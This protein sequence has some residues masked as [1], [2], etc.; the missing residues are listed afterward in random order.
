ML[1]TL[2]SFQT[3]SGGWSKHVD[4]RGP[5]RMPGESFYSEDDRW[6]YIATIDNDATT[7]HLRFL[8]A[9]F[10]AT[11]DTRARDGFTRGIAYLLQAQF[12]NGG[13]P[14]VYPLQGGYHDAITFNDNAMINVLRLLSDVVIGRFPFVSTALRQRA[15]AAIAM[16]HRCLLSTQVVAGGVRRAWGQQHDPLTL[17]PVAGRRYE[18]AALTGRESAEIAKYLMSLPQPPTELVEAVHAAIAWFRVHA[19]Y[20]FDYTMQSGLRLAKNGSMTAPF[21]ARLYEIGTERPLFSDRDGVPKYDWSLL[22]DRRFGYAWFSQEPAKA[23]AVYDT[24]WSIQHPAR[25]FEATDML[26]R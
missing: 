22:T 19:I 13:W 21:W 7:E 12:P 16:G 3:P 6:N 24:F 20:G 15:T 8:A 23:I 18:L 5:K 1:D 11:K 25:A 4:M 2:L 14:Q 26:P 10:A 17:A 9:A